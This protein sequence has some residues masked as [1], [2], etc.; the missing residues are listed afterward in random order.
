MEESKRLRDELKEA[1]KKKDDELKKKDDDLEAALDL[2]KHALTNAIMVLR[3]GGLWCAE[4]GIRWLEGSLVAVEAAERR[5]SPPPCAR[6]RTQ[7]GDLPG[8]GE[9]NA[10]HERP[11]KGGA[12]ADG[13]RRLDPEPDADGA[14]TGGRR[15]PGGL[16]CPQWGVLMADRELRA[17]Y[18]RFQ[19]TLC[20]TKHRLCV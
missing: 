5:L 8:D 2:A 10:D 18:L 3:A 4:E 7:A 20:L 14:A 16:G 15:R 11:E 9:R 19:L 6:V 13:G 1:L 12:L 17:L